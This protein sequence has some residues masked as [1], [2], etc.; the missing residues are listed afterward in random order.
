MQCRHDNEGSTCV[1]KHCDVSSHM[2]N[3]QYCKHFL[4][5]DSLRVYWV[6]I[7]SLRKANVDDSEN[8]IR[9]AKCVLI[10]ILQL[11]WCVR[12]EDRKKRQ[13]AHIVPT[14]SKQV[15]S[16]RGKYEVCEMLNNEKWHVQSVQIS[17]SNLQIF[18]V[19]DAVAVLV[20]TLESFRF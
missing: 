8:I 11:N 5:I 17:C 19:L 16:R 15:I 12:F 1:R 13:S 7:G 18:E 14:T 10:I 4:W 9:L 2:D 20:G 3:R 6:T